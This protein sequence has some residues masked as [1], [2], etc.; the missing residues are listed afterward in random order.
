VAQRLIAKEARLALV[1]NRRNKPTEF[2]YGSPRATRT[3]VGGQLD[4]PATYAAL[5]AMQMQDS[6]QGQLL[7]TG[8]C[9]L[10]TCSAGRVGFACTTD[11]DCG[12]PARAYEIRD[13]RGV[14]LQ[15]F[16]EN[17]QADLVAMGSCA[18]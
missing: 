6:L 18:P 1:V 15:T 5:A 3:D 10:G 4:V 2:Q 16:F 17:L 11:G 8:T 14:N 12:L 13:A 7:A 9:S